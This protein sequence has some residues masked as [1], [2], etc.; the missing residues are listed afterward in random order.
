MRCA[1]R[2]V[3]NFS[4]GLPWLF[5]FSSFPPF[6]PFASSLFRSSAAICNLAGAI[7]ATRCS[8]FSSSPKVLPLNCFPCAFPFA[9]KCFIVLYEGLTCISVIPE[10]IWR[11]TVIVVPPVKSNPSA[12]SNLLEFINFYATTWHSSGYE[13]SQ[14]SLLECKSQVAIVAALIKKKA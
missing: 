3:R 6:P 1:L 4:A 2:Y 7:L 8:A 13:A 9:S 10:L 12:G 11:R 5:R 14:A